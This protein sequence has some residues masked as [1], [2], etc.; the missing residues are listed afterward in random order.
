M[1]YRAAGMD[2]HQRCW[3]SL[4]LT[5]KSKANTNLSGVGG[6]PAEEVRHESYGAGSM[7]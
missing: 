1:S 3:Q 2:A 4:C 5:S 6:A 7:L